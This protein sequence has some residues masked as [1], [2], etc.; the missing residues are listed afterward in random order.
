M[1]RVCIF[2][3]NNTAKLTL[4]D[5]LP[6]WYLRRRRGLG[7]FTHVSWSGTGPEHRHESPLKVGVKIVCGACNNF[8]MSDIQRE[9]SRLLEKMIDGQPITLDSQDQRAVAAWLMMTAITWQFAVPGGK[10]IPEHFINDFYALSAPRKPSTGVAVWIG[11]YSGP[12]RMATY[13]CDIARTIR[14]NPESAARIDTGRDAPPFGATICLESFVA[15]V[16]GF[17]LP[18]TRVR[19]VL[20]DAMKFWQ[21]IWPPSP[22]PVSWPPQ[23]S[24]DEPVLQMLERAFNPSEPRNAAS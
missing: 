13:C 17:S 7:L 6:M 5:V 18:Q 3:R 22:D 9:A 12:S 8:W 11:R 1:A 4:E 16:A 23:E 15:Q 2:C 10:P 19:F 20:R 14:A 24:I 21:P